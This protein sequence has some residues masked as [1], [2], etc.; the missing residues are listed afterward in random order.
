MSVDNECDTT[1]K[2]IPVG[3][4]AAK[5]GDLTFKQPLILAQLFDGDGYLTIRGRH[6]PESDC[7]V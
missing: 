5:L 6:V 7:V 4:K 2:I 1:A 3:S